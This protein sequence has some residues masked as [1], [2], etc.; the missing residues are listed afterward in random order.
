MH[1]DPRT[2]TVGHDERG[3]PLLLDFAAL[4]AS[5]AHSGE[6]VAC[7][8]SDR[9]VGVDVERADRPEADDA[10]AARVCTS[11]ERRQLEHMPA[12]PRKR[13]LNRLWARKEAL[14]KALGVGLAAHSSNST[15]VTTSRSSAALDQQRC[16][17]EMSRAVPMA[18]PWPSQPKVEET[19]CVDTGTEP[20]RCAASGGNRS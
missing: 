14:A 10:L 16:A 1:V 15:S 6:F 2:V 18:M 13:A 4:H 17:C 20:G 7:A 8:L 11:A 19:A 3:R 12:G 5:I 9:R